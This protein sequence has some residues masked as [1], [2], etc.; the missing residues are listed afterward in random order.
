MIIA[1][2]DLFGHLHY[3]LA[4]LQQWDDMMVMRRAVCAV[5][6]SKRPGDDERAL[7]CELN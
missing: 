3:R 4:G 5:V 7:I 2:A 6:R 1:A